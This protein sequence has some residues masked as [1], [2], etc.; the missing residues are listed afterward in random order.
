MNRTDFAFNQVTLY[1]ILG[2][3]F[4]SHPTI[5]EVLSFM[6]LMLLSPHILIRMR[7]FSFIS[8][9]SLCVPIITLF[10]D[11]HMWMFG[12]GNANY[13]Y[14]MGVATMVFVS[15]IPVDFLT[16]SIK[17]LKAA[18]LGSSNSMNSNDDI[19]SSDE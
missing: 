1:A 14:F 6:S 15:T 12:G 17:H 3:V 13:V 8:L 18:K 7:P 16:A 11:Y 5:H 10:V 19:T 2:A 9:I 4:K